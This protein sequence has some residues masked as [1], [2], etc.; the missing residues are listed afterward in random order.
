MSNETLNAMTLARLSY[1]NLS[2]IL[3]LYQKAGSATAI[4]ENRNNIRDIIP[5]ASPKLVELLRD[6]D[7]MMARAEEE[8]EYDLTHDIKPITI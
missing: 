3:Q 7:R 6:C 8:L 2:A 5:D 4:V 1:F